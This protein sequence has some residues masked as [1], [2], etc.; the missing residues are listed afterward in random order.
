[1][2]YYLSNFLEILNAHRSTFIAGFRAWFE[3]SPRHYSIRGLPHDDG[4]KGRV[5]QQDQQNLVASR[6][7][8]DLSETLAGL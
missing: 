2:P 5:I 6:A 7:M 1:L 8:L 3:Q 4:I